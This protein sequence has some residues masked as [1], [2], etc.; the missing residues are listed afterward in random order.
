MSVVW[1]GHVVMVWVMVVEIR[2]GVERGGLKKGGE[3]EGG[4]GSD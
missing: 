4:D 3:E 1:S 2:E